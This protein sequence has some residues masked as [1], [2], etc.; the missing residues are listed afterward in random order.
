M[1]PL[2]TVVELK[3]RVSR[4]IIGQE[5]VVECLLLTLLANG[6][7]LLEGLPSK[8]YL[9]WIADQMWPAQVYVR[10]FLEMFREYLPVQK[11]SPSVDQVLKSLTQQGQPV[12]AE[13]R[14]FTASRALC[15]TNHRSL[16]GTQ[17]SS[18]TPLLWFGCAQSGVCGALDGGGEG[19]HWLRLPQ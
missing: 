8:M 19:A 12:G 2:D 6:N 7:P 4:S 10:T 17:R 15:T 9:R 13:R 14:C 16:C 3:N 11:S 5:T 18:R 1:T